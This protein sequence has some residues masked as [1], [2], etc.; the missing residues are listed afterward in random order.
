MQPDINVRK[1]ERKKLK[2][3]N[4]MGNQF[5]G[6]LPSNMS[7]KASEKLIDL[8]EDKS[9]KTNFHRKQ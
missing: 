3:S 5:Q 1:K 8:S 9:L 2:T 6:Q 4:G 7:T